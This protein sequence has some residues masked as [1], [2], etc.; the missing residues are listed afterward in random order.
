MTNT[1]SLLCC[2]E[3]KNMFLPF[4]KEE[5]NKGQPKILFFSAQYDI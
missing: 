5:D 3:V 2:N 4:M 1:S